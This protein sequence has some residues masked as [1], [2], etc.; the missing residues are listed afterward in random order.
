[1]PFGIFIAFNYKE[2]G[3]TRIEDDAF[4]TTVGSTGAVFNG[5]G[6]LFFGIMFDKFSFKLVSSAINMGLLVFAIVIPYLL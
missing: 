3:F 2:Y 6:R 4:L 1:M 5:L